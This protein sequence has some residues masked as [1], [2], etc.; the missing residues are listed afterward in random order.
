MCLNRHILRSTLLCT[1]LIEVSKI[2]PYFSL[3]Y[4]FIDSYAYHKLILLIPQIM[5][6]EIWKKKNTNLISI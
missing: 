1:T 5:I 4:L 6:K 2:K 3:C